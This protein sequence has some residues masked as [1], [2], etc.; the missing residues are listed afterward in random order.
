ME[1]LQ[2]HEESLSLEEVTAW[3]QSF[4]RLLKHQ[5]GRNILMEFLRSEHSDENILF[6]LACEELKHEDHKATIAEMAK[7]IYLDYI[8]ILSP[9]EM[10]HRKHPI[11]F[12]TAWYCPRP[13]DTT[14]Y[15]SHCL[16]KAGSKIKDPSH[17]AYS[18]FQL[19]P[20]GRRYKSLRTYT[21][22]FKNSF[23]SAVTAPKRPSYGLM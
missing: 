11:G 20:S 13:E 23:F 14:V 5:T 12:I 6:W 21:N 15:N 3:S 8:S 1:S 2:K 16:G 9:K 7:S 19:L 4:E 10:H 18:L 17:P 22:R